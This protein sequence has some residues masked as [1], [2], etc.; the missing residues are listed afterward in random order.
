MM[1]VEYST[2]FFFF[3]KFEDVFVIAFFIFHFFLVFIKGFF[4][5]FFFTFHFFTLSSQFKFLC[6]FFLFYIN[7]KFISVEIDFVDLYMNIIFDME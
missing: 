1:D 6:F 2:N 7:Q 3:Y 5:F 4:N